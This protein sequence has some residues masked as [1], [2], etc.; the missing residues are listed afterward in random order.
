GLIAVVV[1]P[2][3]AFWFAVAMIRTMGEALCRVVTPPPEIGSQGMFPGEPCQ[4]FSRTAR[5]RFRVHG[6]DTVVS[7]LNTASSD[8]A[9]PR[10]SVVQARWRPLA[11]RKSALPRVSA[12]LR[13][14]R[15][16]AA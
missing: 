7:S 3:A 8:C 1:L 11:R 15:A 6:I 10:G 12:R 16:A 13:T 5:Q 9:I 14:A 4:R 2:P